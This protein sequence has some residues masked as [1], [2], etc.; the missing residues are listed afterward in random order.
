MRSVCGEYVFNGLFT[1]FTTC[2]TS[3]DDCAVTVP[4]HIKFADNT[5]NTVKFTRSEGKRQT[6]VFALM[7]KQ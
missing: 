1:I 2:Q 7:A 4:S 3:K 6:L 5:V